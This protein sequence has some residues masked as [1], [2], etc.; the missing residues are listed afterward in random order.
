MLKGRLRR[1]QNFVTLC[2]VAGARLPRA[3]QPSQVRMVD[4]CRQ[5]TKGQRW[6]FVEL[7]HWWGGEGV[8][9]HG[10]EHFCI[11]HHCHPWVQS[12]AQRM[13]RWWFRCHL[14]NACRQGSGCPIKG[15][16]QRHRQGIARGSRVL[17]QF[18]RCIAFD[19]GET[20]LL[21]A[22]SRVVVRQS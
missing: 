1:F 7:L 21:D 2:E 16:Q 4:K 20:Q 3:P 14:I 11:F 17:L 15:H 13:S 6:R 12:S 18:W 22:L 10:S 19:L 9:H 8:W 5:R